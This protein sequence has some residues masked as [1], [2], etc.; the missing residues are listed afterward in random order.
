MGDRPTLP[1]IRNRPDA[2]IP[3]PDP[4]PMLGPEDWASD[5]GAGRQVLS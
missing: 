2:L 5:D 1:L 4:A 3:H